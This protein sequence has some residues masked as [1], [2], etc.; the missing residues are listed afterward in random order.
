MAKA[1]AKAKLLERVVVGPKPIWTVNPE[2]GARHKA[3]IGETVH[4]APH[5]AKKFARYL[6]DPKVAKARAVAAKAEED[7]ADAE[8]EAPVAAETEADSDES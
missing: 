2:T 7:S 5:T 4:L 3:E 8:A 6:A 1:K